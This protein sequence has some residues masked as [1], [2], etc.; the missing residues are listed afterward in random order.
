M[1]LDLP[2]TRRRGPGAR[3]TKE[4]TRYARIVGRNI[5]RLRS[6]RG[7]T[8]E[9]LAAAVTESGYPVSVAVLGFL[10]T[11]RVGRRPENQHRNVSVDQMMAFAA[12]FGCDPGELLNPACR[13]C[14]GRP[15]AGFTC[16]TCGRTADV[17]VSP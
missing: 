2:A 6:Q 1:T 14:D 3:L 13:A 4:T 8:Q 17:P 16:N 10:E 11:G 5:A 15:P 12:Y 9:Q 7:L